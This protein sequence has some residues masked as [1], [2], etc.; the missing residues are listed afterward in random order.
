VAVLVGMLVQHWRRLRSVRGTGHILKVS[1]VAKRT[2]R[3]AIRA[4]L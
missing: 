4:P 3:R 1:G 2:N